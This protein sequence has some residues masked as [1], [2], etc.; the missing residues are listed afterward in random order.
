M[1]DT[2]Q[3]H[4]LSF[5]K[6]VLTQEANSLLSIRDQLSTEFLTAI[7]IIL[8]T[9][10]RVILS[11]MG[12]SGHVATKIAATLA[13][14]GTPSF[15]VHPAEAN[16]GDLGMITPDDCLILLSNSGET[17]ELNGIIAYA[18][19]FSIP[20]IAM[21]GK[22]DSTLVR[23]AHV[24]L[25]MNVEEACPLKLAPTTS[26]T[27][28]MAMGDALAVAL[29][30]IKSFGAH[31][32]KI[33]HPGG[34]LGQQLTHVRE[35]MHKNESIPTVTDQQFM[36]D[37]IVEISSK[38]FGCVGIINH[39]HQLIGMITDGDLRRHM[40]DNL[41]SL[42]VTAVMTPMP[43]TISDDI[44]MAEALSFMEKYTI[45]SLFVVNDKKVPVGIIHIHDFLR[46]GIL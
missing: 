32:F 21:S 8:K 10:G 25:I 28:M 38:G 44:T 3:Q 7:D 34:K 12:K 4:I 33:F 11:G 17:P 22:A 15:F 31:D 26:T 41:M 9:K 43:R 29:L 23:S 24:G 16:H 2:T 36:G 5:G 37:A 27:C 42:A 6:D 18:K 1:A 35:K 30:K 14:T 19:R 45:T 13:S 46:H 40:S 39:A 20:T